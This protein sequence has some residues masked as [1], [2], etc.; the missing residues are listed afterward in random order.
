MAV[1]LS[2]G[3]GSG[4][5]AKEEKDEG[6]MDKGLS[7]SALSGLIRSFFYAH[8]AIR[9]AHPFVLTVR[10]GRLAHTSFKVSV[11]ALVYVFPLM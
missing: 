4:D 11:G 7:K 5:G 8:R 9:N 3:C 2:A 6:L 1:L 10:A